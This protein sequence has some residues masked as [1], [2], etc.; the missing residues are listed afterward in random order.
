MRVTRTAAPLPRLVS[1]LQT[2]KATIQCRLALLRVALLV[3]VKL[4]ATGHLLNF[5]VA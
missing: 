5:S 4:N 3:R 1:Y 2:R